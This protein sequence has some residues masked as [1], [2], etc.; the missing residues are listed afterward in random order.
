MHYFLCVSHLVTLTI[1]TLS[2]CGRHPRFGSMGLACDPPT[3]SHLETSQSV[4]IRICRDD[5]ECALEPYM[6]ECRRHP[7]ELS[8]LGVRQSRHPPC[9]V[10]S[11][12]QTKERQ[13]EHDVPRKLWVVGQKN[14]A[15]SPL[16][17]S[18]KHQESAQRFARL[19]PCGSRGDRYCRRRRTGGRKFFRRR[20]LNHVRHMSSAVSTPI[21][22]HVNSKLLF[23]AQKPVDVRPNGVVRR[24]RT[25]RASEGVRAPRKP[26]PLHH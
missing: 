16:A 2:E 19:R 26:M 9:L 4:D 8:R 12:F 22:M 14:L 13:F 15:D 11:Q 5:L 21:E 17:Q 7:L 3:L 10:R 1:Q 18:R 23:E 25:H 20:H 24:T 6:R